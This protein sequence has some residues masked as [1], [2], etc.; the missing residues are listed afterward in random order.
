MG[1]F[2][3]DPGVAIYIALAAALACW[4]GVFIFL[5]RIDRATHELRRRLEERPAPEQTAPRATVE[6]R[7]TET[8]HG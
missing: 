1:G 5:W 2:L 6:A 4:I 8:A 7:K 3:L